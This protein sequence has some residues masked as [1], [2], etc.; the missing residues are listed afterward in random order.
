MCKD[1]YHNVC[2]GLS[3]SDTNKPDWLCT[4]C[5]PSI[6][7]FHNVDYKTLVKLTSCDKYSLENVTLLTSDMSRICSICSK[8]LHR[9]NPGIPCHSCKSKIHVKCSKLSDPKNNFHTFKGNWQ[10]E[11]CMKNKFPFAEIDDDTLF[12][13]SGNS[14]TRKC[15]FLPEFSIDEKLKI[16]LSHSSKSNW[17]DHISDDHET[18]P[19]DNFNDHDTKPN[20]HYYDVDDFRKTQQTWD[21]HKSLSLFH[22]N[23]ASL[24]TNFDKMEDLLVD[25]AWTFDIIAVSETRN[26][27]KNKVNFNAPLMEGYHEYSGITGSSQN[28]GCGFYIKNT[29]NKNPRN[30]FD[31]KIEDQGAQS[32]CH[33]EE[34]ISDKGPNILLGVFYRHPSHR[35]DKFLAQLDTT[36]KKV[37]RENKKTIICGDFNIDL[38]S[39]DREKR[40]STFLSTMLEH[41]FQPCITEP[42]R[43]TNTNKPSL[44]DNI[45]TNSFENPVSGNILEQISYDHLPNFVILDNADI[46]KLSE[47]VKRDKKNLNITKFQNDLLGD[48]LIVNIINAKDTDHACDIFLDKYR[49]LLEQHVPLRKLT[50]KELKQKQKPWITQG[51]IKSIS[52]KRA[53]FVKIKKL[54]S[55]NKNTDEVFKL[56]KVYNNTINKLKRKCKRDFYQEYFNKNSSNSKKVW[57]G[58]NKLLNRGKKKQGTIFLEENGLISDPLK[59]ANKFNDFYCNVADKLCKKIPKVNNKFQDYLKKN[60]KNKLTLKETTPDEVVKIINDLDGKKVVTFITFPLILLNSMGR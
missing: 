16:L 19:Y 13:L 41:N 18:D 34:L 52:K 5:R 44:V 51:L 17:Y 56:Y 48:D 57:Q 29:F 31:F 38:L 2:A 3:K 1:L 10:C 60:N 32:E 20:F 43:I 25:L 35:A 49:T 28:G 15:E 23:I 39:F 30:E 46:R 22:T 40:V 58:I 14:L 8:A 33:W 21:R 59:V 37:K 47:S 7:P 55:K 24:Q 45:F 11:S 50:K 12:E 27:E 6:F 42:T 36:L 9:T 4:T 54:K 53:L 26:D